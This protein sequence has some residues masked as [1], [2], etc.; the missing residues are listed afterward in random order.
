MSPIFQAL[1][2]TSIGSCCW[3]RHNVGQDALIRF[4]VLHVV[5]LP[6]LAGTLIGVHFWRIRK[7]GGLSRPPDKF[8]PDPYESYSV[9]TQ[10]NLLLRGQTNIW[11]DG[12]V[13]RDMPDSRQRAL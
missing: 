9:P 11:P 4:Y 6:L 2:I 12:L 13:Q 8:R 1:N 10:R 3:L 5:F 7:D